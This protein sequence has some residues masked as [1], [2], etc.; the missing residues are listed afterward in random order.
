MTPEE[1][2]A[3]ITAMQ[4]EWQT[5]WRDKERIII[6]MEPDGTYTIHQHTKDSVYCPTPKKTAREVAA[7]MLQLLKVGPTA[8]QDWPEEIGIGELTYK[9][10]DII[11]ISK[12]PH[13][14]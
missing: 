8:P 10:A 2:Y 6:V 9:S 12:E 4:A 3:D 1:N 5:G 7:R 13:E 14:Q 11:P